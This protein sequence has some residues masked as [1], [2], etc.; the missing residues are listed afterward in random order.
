M[1][2]AEVDSHVQCLFCILATETS[3]GLP[4]A[5]FDF[6]VGLCS[7]GL[8]TAVRFIWMDSQDLAT[9]LEPF[10]TALGDLG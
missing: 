9:I 5:L 8:G 4:F 10:Q 3:G 1:S 2:S 7:R 6:V